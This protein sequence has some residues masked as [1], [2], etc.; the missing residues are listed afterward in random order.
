MEDITK[1]IGLLG[2]VPFVIVF[3]WVMIKDRTGIGRFALLYFS[4]IGFFILVVG[5]LIWGI[6]TLGGLL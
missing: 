4:A 3:V 1:Y 5:G 2:F 6:T